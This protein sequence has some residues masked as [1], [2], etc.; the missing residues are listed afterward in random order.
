VPCPQAD[1]SHRETRDCSKQATG[2]RELLAQCGELAEEI[3]AGAF[4][5]SGTDVRTVIVTM[6][7]HRMP[8]N[9]A[10]R[11]DAGDDTD[12]EA[13]GTGGAHPRPRG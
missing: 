1:P 13:S 9:Q 11:E 3:E 5:A 7:A 12:P 6:E 8:W 4:R 10:L 2:F